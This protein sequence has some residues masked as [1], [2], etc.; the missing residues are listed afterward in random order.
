LSTVLFFGFLF[1]NTFETLAI[2]AIFY[3]ISL[4]ISYLHFAKLN[5]QHEK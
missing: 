3:F 2:L 5:K 1:K 4:P